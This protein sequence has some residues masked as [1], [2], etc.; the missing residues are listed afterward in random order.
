MYYILFIFLLSL[1]FKNGPNYYLQKFIF[2]KLEVLPPGN[3]EEKKVTYG[4]LWIKL[5]DIKL[6]KHTDTSQKIYLQFWGEDTPIILQAGNS[7]N[8]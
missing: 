8:P 5:G 7:N 1:L 6:F 2:F 4:I 3:I